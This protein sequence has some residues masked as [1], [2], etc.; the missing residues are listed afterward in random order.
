[1]AIDKLTPFGK[2]VRKHRID[3]G[4][5]LKEMADGVGLTSAWLSAIESGQKPIPAGLA[6]KISIFLDLDIEKQEELKE[7]AER[8]KSVKITGVRA[9]RQDVATVLARRFNDIGEDDLNAI[10][11][12]L[13][14]RKG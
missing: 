5:L 9:D 11:D 2:Q 7:L 13:S 1:M 14:K 3:R 12:I 4:M 6:E 10:R 8:S